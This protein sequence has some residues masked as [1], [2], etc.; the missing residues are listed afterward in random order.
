MG[1][2]HRRSS[3]LVVAAT[4]I[5]LILTIP[6][7]SHMA[8][9]AAEAPWERV[10]P[11]VSLLGKVTKGIDFSNSTPQSPR[12]QY[13]VEVRLK[14]TGSSP[15]TYDALEFA[16]IAALGEPLRARQTEHDARTEAVKTVT[17]KPDEEKRWEFTTNGYTN[18]LLRRS[19]SQPLVFE[20][21][22]R[23]EGRIVAGPFRAELPDLG[24]LPGSGRGTTA[25]AVHLKFG[26]R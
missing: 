7:T 23:L 21:S 10:S 20:M 8:L 18:E 3:S 1:P 2:E 25:P 9:L 15:I 5:A 26:S 13:D 11:Q 16:F 6:P 17:I 12:F 22:L 4:V 19:Q 24:R 14:N